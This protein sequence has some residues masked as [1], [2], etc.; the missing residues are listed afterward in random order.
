MRELTFPC[1]TR[2]EL[3][4]KQ[5]KLVNFKEY[6]RYFEQRFLDYKNATPKSKKP[7]QLEI[8]FNLKRYLDFV[9]SLLTLLKNLSFEDEEEWWQQAR[10]SNEKKIRRELY[11]FDTGPWYRTYW[12]GYNELASVVS[13]ELIERFEQIIFNEENLRFLQEYAYSP[14]WGTQDYNF[15]WKAEYYYRHKFEATGLEKETL[16][17]YE[18]LAKKER[19]Y[20]DKC[21]ALAYRIRGDS[22][23]SPFNVYWEMARDQLGRKWPMKQE[24]RCSF[25][26]FFRYIRKLFQKETRQPA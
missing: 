18:R 20:M 21:T 12:Q 26:S 14:A 19:K 13:S 22:S 8:E 6:D 24:G 5:Y 23:A 10:E 3:Q 1:I 2:E 4:K 9:L 17:K 7:I 15:F 11:D 25:L 16:E